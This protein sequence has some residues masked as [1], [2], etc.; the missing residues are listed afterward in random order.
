VHNSVATEDH[1]GEAACDD[2]EKKASCDGVLHWEALKVVPAS[3]T[4][5]EGYEAGT[6]SLGTS[7]GRIP[8]PKACAKAIESISNRPTWPGGRATIAGR[9]TIYDPLWFQLRPR[10]YTGGAGGF[11]GRPPVHNFRCG[12]PLQQRKAPASLLGLCTH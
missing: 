5:V 6:G 10:R 7:N 11:A 9:V 8:F 12:L 3:A 1:S 4:G 2:R